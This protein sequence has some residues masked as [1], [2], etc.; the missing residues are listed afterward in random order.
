MFK[1]QSLL[2]SR[3]ALL[4]AIQ[5]TLIVSLGTGIAYVTRHQPP[6]LGTTNS[7]EA[8]VIP[9]RT[10][11]YRLD[12]EFR[13]GNLGVDAPLAV[14]R[15]REFAIMKFQV[16][17]SEYGACVKAGACAKPERGD[18][19]PE[20]PVT[21]VSY[22]DASA[23]AVWL[24]KETG[25]DWQLPTDDQ[26]AAAAGTKFPDDAL[27][28]DPDSA[29]PSL[30]WIADYEREA[31]ERSNGKVATRPKGG[32]GENEFGLADFGGNVW[33]WTST[34]HRRVSLNRSGTWN[35]VDTACGVYVTV[36]KHRSPMSSF[37]RD[38][39]GGGCAVGTPPDNLGFRLVRKESLFDR[40]VGAL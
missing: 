35:S 34:C 2:R 23:Y 21:G 13:K 6:P 27:G 24:S 32:F 3:S 11:T 38:P 28:I 7:P 29:N 8:V 22:D 19:P 14:T 16:T 39:K 33:E 1:I 9:P 26:L 15:S 4:T 18:D 17:V 31:R 20:Y 30:R 25:E 36:G 37:I 12:G 10:F 40:L 5:L